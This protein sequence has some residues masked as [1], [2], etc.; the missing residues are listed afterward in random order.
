[1]IYL[2]E[3]R[4]NFYYLR[5]L[6]GIDLEPC[7]Q[8]HDLVWDLIISFRYFFEAPYLSLEIDS[9]LRELHT[10]CKSVAFDFNVEGSP[11]FYES[12]VFHF[13]S[14]GVHPTSSSYMNELSARM[15]KMG[16]TICEILTYKGVLN[17]CIKIFD[18]IFRQGIGSQGPEPYFEIPVSYAAYKMTSHLREA[19]ENSF[20]AEE[21]SPS[22]CVLYRNHYIDRELDFALR[23]LE[24]VISLGISYHPD[25]IF[26]KD[27]YG[28]TVCD[29]FYISGWEHIWKQ[30]L[31]EHGIGPDWAFE[32]DERRKRVVV[33]DTSAHEVSVG[34]DTFEIL[35]VQRRRAFE[36]DEN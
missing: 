16:S 13:G 29:R 30:I 36:A 5:G 21:I 34:F 12:I 35:Q 7:W 15:E 24:H 3:T 4:D 33:G 32:E 19:R 31:E 22:L 2:H 10:A 20:I 25:C 9:F 23:F 26:D 27:E 14:W 28:Y 11:S 1:V 17:R 18:A 8:N 6:S